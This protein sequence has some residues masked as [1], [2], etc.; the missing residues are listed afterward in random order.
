MVG[1]VG[2]YA[3]DDYVDKYYLIKWTGTP[4]A[5][6]EDQEIII[7][8]TLSTVLV[9]EWICNGIWLDQVARAKFWYT[10]GATTVT[11]RMKNVLNVDL[12][13]NPNSA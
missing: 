5:F 6:T 2:A 3:V 12:V 10:V 4:K 1:G 13:M 8:N 11:V 9:G 7:E